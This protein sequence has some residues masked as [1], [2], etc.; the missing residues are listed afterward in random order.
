M[1]DCEIEKTL[2]H[3]VIR[4]VLMA[5]TVQPESWSKVM[6][7]AARTILRQG[8]GQRQQTLCVASA[9]GRGDDLSTGVATNGNGRHLARA[10]NQARVDTGRRQ[11]QSPRLSMQSRVTADDARLAT[12]DSPPVT[13]GPPRVPSWSPLAP[14]WT[15]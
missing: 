14:R 8:T 7:K 13:R 4:Y 9:V 3:R 5:T 12:G 6:A 15:R 10:I 11:A 1:L 2:Q